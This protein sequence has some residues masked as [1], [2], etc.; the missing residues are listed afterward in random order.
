MKPD[1]I[2]AEVRKARAEIFRQ[3]GGDVAKL[4]ER[5]RREDAA[6]QAALPRPGKRKRSPQTTA[7]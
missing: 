4:F 6:R 3:C 5:L 7:R 2:V 1:P